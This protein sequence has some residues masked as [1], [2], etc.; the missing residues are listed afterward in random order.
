ML[1]NWSVL[2]ILLQV[3]PSSDDSQIPPET[4]PAIILLESATSIASARV[5]PPTLYGPR[6]DHFKLELL[7][8]DLSKSAGIPFDPGNVFA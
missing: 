4:P 8:L 3:I 1:C 7:P 2:V 6:S 5:L